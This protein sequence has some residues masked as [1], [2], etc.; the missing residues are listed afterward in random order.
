MHVGLED[1]TPVVISNPAGGDPITV[2][3]LNPA[4][5]G[6]VDIVDVTSESNTRRYNGFDLSLNARLPRGGVLFGGL[7]V[8]KT[9]NVT[10]DVDDANLLRFCDQ[11]DYV[12]Y[13]VQFKMSGNVRLVKGVQL[14][15]V[16]QSNPGLPVP[17]SGSNL[18]PEAGLAVNYNVGRAIVPNL[19][20][21]QVVVPLIEP[22]SSYLDRRYQFDL[23]LSKTMRIARLELQGM[24]DMFN[25]LNSNVVLNLIQTYGPALDRP[26]EILQGR[27]FRFSLLTKF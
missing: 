19:T 1:Y 9:A 6:L 20:Q 12:P 3:N 7:T 2:Y 15:M 14:G 18:P 5:F 23:R 13:L 8:G 22:G 4:K 27:M 25:A 24:F 10:C 21:T 26:V 11:S 16:F 17:S